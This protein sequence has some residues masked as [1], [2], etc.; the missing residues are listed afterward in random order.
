MIFRFF[1]SKAELLTKTLN[2]DNCPNNK[3]YNGQCRMSKY[4]QKIPYNCHEQNFNKTSTYHKQ[5]NYFNRKRTVDTT[6]IFLYSGDPGSLSV[7]SNT[8]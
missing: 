1:A 2:I 4:P 6:L 8:P 3:N 5:C 7:I